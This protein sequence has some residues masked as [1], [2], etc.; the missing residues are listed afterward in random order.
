MTDLQ[1]SGTKVGVPLRSVPIIVGLSVV[2]NIVA[3]ERFSA[4]SGETVEERKLLN[5]ELD[6]ETGDQAW[7]NSWP[8]NIYLFI[9][10]ESWSQFNLLKIFFSLYG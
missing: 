1:L 10:L 6:R 5:E 9:V 7:S 3:G 2:L 4:V 8:F